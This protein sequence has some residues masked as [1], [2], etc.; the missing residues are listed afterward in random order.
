MNGR[1]KPPAPPLQAAE[2]RVTQEAPGSDRLSHELQVHRIE[3]EM[4][5]EA[6]RESQ[7]ALE[8]SRDRYLRLYEFAPVGYLT[9]TDTGVIAEANLTAATLLGVAR[10]QLLQTRFERYVDPAERNRWQ[11]LLSGHPQQGLQSCELP[12]RRANGES[13]HALLDCRE[14]V[15]VTEQHE[16]RFTFSDISARKRMELALSRS[17]ESFRRL[18]QI[19]PAAIFRAD[20]QGA[21]T[22]ANQRCAESAGRPVA[23]L[24]G[25]GWLRVMHPEDRDRV[26]A[27]WRHDMSERRPKALEW[28]IL[29]PDGSIRWVLSEAAAELDER[30]KPIGYISCLSDIT[31]LREREE[32]RRAEIAEHRDTLIREVHHRIKNNLQSVAGLLQREL[33]R[34]V[35]LNPRLETAISQV[36]AIAV[37]HGL[38]SSNPEEAVRL[39]DSVSNICRTVSD[40]SQRPVLFHIEH[41]HTA[42]TPVRI[43]SGEAVPVALILNELILNAVK[44]SPETGY[45]PTVALSAD[46]T[47]ARIE[48]RNA[49]QHLPDFDIETG[50]GLGTG[51]RLVRSLLPSAGATLAYERDDAGLVVTKLLLGEPVVRRIHPKGAQ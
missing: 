37:V 23:D 15:A 40:L 1:R 16:T 2:D 9:L 50:L 12:M 13:F 21:C 5:N 48:I 11:R 22:Y 18:A 34:F 35:E 39:C 51:L 25:E 20:V 29:R 47:S 46:G 32:R 27:E 38:Q 28:R 26:L 14:Q 10:G 44:H 45:A 17:E 24:L 31:E 49:P 36:H 41:E 19:S 4:Q 43:E 8:A 42:F 30:G 3:L 7:V 6:L 33:G